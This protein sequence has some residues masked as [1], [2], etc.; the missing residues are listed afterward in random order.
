MPRP[1]KHNLHLPPCVYLRH[2]AYY[3]VRKGVWERLGTDLPAALAEYGRRFTNEPR[4]GMAELIEEALPVICRGKAENTQAQYRIAAYKLKQMLA[5]VTPQSVRPKDVAQVKRILASTPNMA[6]RCLT[7]LRLVFSYAVEEQIIDSNPCVG[8]KRHQEARRKRY[9]TDAEFAAIYSKAGPRLQVIM[10][11]QYLTGQRINDVLNLRRSAIT[12]AGILLT[13]Q[14]V[15]NSSGAQ[16]LLR[17]TPELRMVVDRAKALNPRFSTLTLLHGRN[18]KAPD[19]GTV[20]L[21]WRKAAKGAGVQDVRPNDPRAKSAT[22]A[23]KQGKNPRALLGHTSD[24][25]T[26]RYLRQHDTPKVDGPSFGR[27][28]GQRAKNE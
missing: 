26:E 2:G 24:A 6:N 1:R 18:G 19:Y 20:A 17:W 8:I 11:L 4:G 28:I 23:K 16:M 7:V 21:Q 27:S 5:E 10:D 15:E 9:L 3:L 12:E 14:K 13:P 22:D 25:M